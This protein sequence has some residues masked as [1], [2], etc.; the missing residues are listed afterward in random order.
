MA[1]CASVY[2]SDGRSTSTTRGSASRP[3]RRTAPSTARSASRLC[4]GMRVG[5]SRGLTRASHRGSCAMILELIRGVRQEISAVV[6]DC[7]DIRLIC[8]R[9][10][11]AS[12]GQRVEKTRPRVTS[13]AWSGRRADARLLAADDADFQ[14]SNDIGV[15]A[16]GDDRLSER[17]D[18]LIELHTLALHFHAVLVENLDQVL[19]RDRAEQ[20]AFLRRLAPFLVGERLD[21][22]AQRLGIALDT[23][24]FGVRLF[25]DVLEVLEIARGGTERQ[26]LGDQEISR[27]AVGDVADLAAPAELLH[28]VEQNDLH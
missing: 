21:P 15:Q 5:T 6:D 2:K 25:L 27:V 4:G 19:R 28:V 23:I 11:C 14:L 13:G 22:A 16:N 18:G 24:R 20:L 7:V 3:S 12:G 1:R 17:F 9:D 8:D 10:R 26:L